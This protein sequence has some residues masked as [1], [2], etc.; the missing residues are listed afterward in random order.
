MVTRWTQQHQKQ[1]VADIPTLLRLNLPFWSLVGFT[2]VMMYVYTEYHPYDIMA[3][4]GII[5]HL[6]DNSQK[7]KS[8]IIVGL[9][10]ILMSKCYWKNPG[11]NHVNH[12]PSKYSYVFFLEVMTVNMLL[13]YFFCYHTFVLYNF[14]FYSIYHITD[15]VCVC[16]I[17]YLIFISYI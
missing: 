9:G 14:I 15:S 10:W 2:D 6:N 8:K 17:S 13:F 5:F 4:C 16:I 11:D 3:A 7:L 1:R 12:I